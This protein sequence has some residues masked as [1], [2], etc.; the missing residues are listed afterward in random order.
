VKRVVVIGLGAVAAIAVAVWALGAVAH[1]EFFVIRRVEVRG[2]QYLE[3][4]SIVAALDLEP[5]AHL[6][7]PTKAMVGRVLQIP[8]VD[9]TK[10]GRRWPGTL[11]VTVVERAPVALA[12]G[13]A[14]LALMD[15]EGRILP[16]D[17]RQDPQRLPVVEPD[18]AVAD[19]LDRVRE[20]DPGLFEL[21]D[22]AS[23]VREGVALFAADKRY[24]VRRR[25]AK[26]AIQDLAAVI[27]DLQERGYSYRELD[28]R[29]A[30][31]VFVRM[32]WS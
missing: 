21:I 28:A 23:R 14:G 7:D 12:S 1:S 25:P 11:V 26:E 15:G 17:P 2:T 10:V 3:P 6:F 29:F 5:D 9:A 32:R 27:R 4:T 8:G 30:S 31:R 22:R 18:V 19:V 16:F 13:K 24:L 20:T